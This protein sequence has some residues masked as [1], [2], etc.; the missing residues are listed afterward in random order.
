MLKSWDLERRDKTVKKRRGAW[1]K[2][3]EVMNPYP[4]GG[5]DQEEADT[6]RGQVGKPLISHRVPMNSI[7]SKLSRKLQ[8]SLKMPTPCFQGS[9]YSGS[10]ELLYARCSEKAPKSL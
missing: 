7:T 1:G 5:C 10:S 9:R 3:S 2:T 8:E 6:W 4:E